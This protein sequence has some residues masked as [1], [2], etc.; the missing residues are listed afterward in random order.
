[1]PKHV[2]A[3][4]A[5]RVP[6][7]QSCSTVASIMARCC[8]ALLGWNSS[9]SSAETFP[10]TSITVRAVHELCFGVLGVAAQ[11][12]QLGLTGIGALATARSLEDHQRAGV[13]GLTP[14]R[15][16]QR[17]EPF[18]VRRRPDLTRPRVR[19]GP[20]HDP[21]LGLCGRPPATGPGNRLRVR[22][23]KRLD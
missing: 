6:I 15:Q 14:L 7:T 3:W 17:V 21:R 12:L 1:M 9:S 20:T 16:M 13:V 22:H 19:V 8:P 23:S 5:A 4:E 11:R 18:A 10:C 2:R